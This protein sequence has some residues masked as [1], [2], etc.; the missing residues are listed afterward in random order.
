MATPPLRP[1]QLPSCYQDS[2]TKEEFYLGGA[3]II[4][5]YSDAKNMNKFLASDIASVKNPRLLAMKE[6]L[7]PFNLQ[8][9]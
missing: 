8:A 6:K 3:K 2:C 5:I 9:E 7:L 1:R 4:H